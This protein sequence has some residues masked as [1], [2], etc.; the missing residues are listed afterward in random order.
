MQIWTIYEF[1]VLFTRFLQQLVSI[2][3]KIISY[4]FD[5]VVSLALKKLKP[6]NKNENC[7]NMAKITLN[8]WSG[9]LFIGYHKEYVKG[10]S[11]L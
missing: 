1:V 5:G 11:R 8:F 10:K 4:K 6:L 7:I 9:F 2:P 3:I